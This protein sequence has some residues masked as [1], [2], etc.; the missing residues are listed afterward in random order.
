MKVADCSLDEVKIIQPEVF[1]DPRGFFMETWNHSKYQQFGINIE[2]KQT[3]LSR[4]SAGVLRGLHY[5]WPEPQAKLVQVLEGRV[6]DVAVD[7]RPDSSNYLQWVGVELSAQNQ[8]QLYIPEGFAHGFLV[9]SESALLA[10]ACSRVFSATADAA[11]AWDDPDIGIRWPS[12]PA[13]VSDKDSQAPRICELDRA[14]LP[15]TTI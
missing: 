10:Y 1:A 15:S 4:S 7:I 9:L 5:Q 8:R 14:R 3:N 13:S 11:I 12:V 2:F 6:F